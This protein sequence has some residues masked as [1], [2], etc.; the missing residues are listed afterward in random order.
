[1]IKI[2]LRRTIL[3]AMLV[4]GALQAGDRIVLDKLTITGNQELP[5]VTYIL[6]WQS[7]PA[8]NLSD[9]PLDNLI[10]EALTPV[11][12][13]TFRRQIYYYRTLTATPVPEIIPA[14]G[15]K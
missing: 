13:E 2:W 7:P 8:P 15:A 1:M 4:C 11:D 3:C 14:H 5:R 9:P 10:D 6:P 12:R